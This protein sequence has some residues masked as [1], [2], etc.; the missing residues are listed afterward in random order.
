MGSN[1]NNRGGC[2][3]TLIIQDEGWNKMATFKWNSGNKKKQNEIIQTLND[4]FGIKLKTR[5][6]TSWMLD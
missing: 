2:N 6:D 5:T 4:A 3:I 1:S